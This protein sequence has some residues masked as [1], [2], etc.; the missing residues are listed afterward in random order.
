MISQ[1]NIVFCDGCGA[2][3]GWAPVVVAQQH[4]CCSECAEGRPCTCGMQAE[5]EDERRNT[6]ALGVDG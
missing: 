5:W 1:E 2:E 3:I 6:P 4:Y